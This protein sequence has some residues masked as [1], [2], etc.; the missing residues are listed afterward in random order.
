[1]TSNVTLSTPQTSGLI[2]QYYLPNGSKIT[3]PDGTQSNTLSANP[4]GNY[5]ADFAI[6]DI[7]QF[8]QQNLQTNLNLFYWTADFFGTDTWKVSR[9]LTLTLG[10]RFDHLGPWQDSRNNGIAIFSPQIYANPVSQML[11]GLDWHGIDHSVPNSGAPG[12]PF[13]FSPR[14]G[15]AYDLSGNGS[16]IVR[17]GFGLYRSHDSGND[18]AQA[19]ATAQGVF[20]STAG[21]SGINLTKLAK[22]TT[23]LADCANPTLA[24]AN[25]KCPSLNATVYGLDGKDTEQPLTY[26]YNLTFTQRL[27]KK[28]VFQVAY[29]G[30]QSHD[31]LLDGNL[32]NVNAL[33]I[34][35]FC[36]R[37]DYRH[38][39]LSQFTFNRTAG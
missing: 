18:Y 27:P 5:L 8:Y 33:P 39:C 38:F 20:I 35:P 4:A 11:P 10:M 14:F 3:N 30:S 22:G 37:S 6:G 9:R 1:M 12:R 16:S 19:A 32:Q 28:S 13:F 21:G 24:N 34:A 7:T 36:C 2:T 25:S 17:G 26:T 15:I 29:V 23:S 31:L